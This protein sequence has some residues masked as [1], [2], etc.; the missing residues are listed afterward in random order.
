MQQ[1][2]LQIAASKMSWE[3]PRQC[4]AEQDGASRKAKLHPQAVAI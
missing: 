3:G 4:S 1:E 2:W